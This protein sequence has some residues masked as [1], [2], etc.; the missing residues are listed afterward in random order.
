MK[1]GEKRFK[2]KGCLAE[3]HSDSM[4]IKSLKGNI[5]KLK[6]SLNHRH[7]GQEAAALTIQPLISG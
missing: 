1:A 4:H 6:Q 2:S 5:K 3:R 7:V